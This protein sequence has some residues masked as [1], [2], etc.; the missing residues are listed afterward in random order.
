LGNFSPDHHFQIIGHEAENGTRY[1]ILDGDSLVAFDLKANKI[2][3]R[4]FNHPIATSPQLFTFPD[5]TV[6]IGIT[7]SVEN[8]IYLLNSD[9]SDCSG[10]PLEGNSPFALHFNGNQSGT[11]NVITGTADGYVKWDDVRQGKPEL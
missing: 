1:L 4:K 10:F 11:F 2:F 6:K 5:K 8:K 9:G 3:A 7:D